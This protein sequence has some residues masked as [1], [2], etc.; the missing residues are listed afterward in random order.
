MGSDHRL[1]TARIC[2]SLRMSKT[3]ATKKCYDWLHYEV[4]NSRTFIRS[5]TVR[6]RFAELSNNSD[7]ITEQYGKFVQANGEAAEKLIPIKK[8]TKRRKIADE[9]RVDEARREVQN[10][11]SNYQK[12]TNTESTV[13]A[14]EER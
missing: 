4:H 7:N 2:L 14:K 1:V 12:H 6:N 5:V 10:A 13:F 3:P 9:P 8:K 11:F